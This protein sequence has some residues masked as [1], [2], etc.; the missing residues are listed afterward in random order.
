MAG[1]RD[2][3]LG[4]SAAEIERL[5]F[6][7]RVLE[8]VTERLIRECGVGPGMRAL[9]IGCGVGD[10]S[11]L[12]A[13]AVGESGVVVGIDREAR[14]VEIARERAAKAGYRQIDF[15]V[16]SDENLL[17]YP[18]FDAAVGRYV[19]VHQQDPAATVRRAAAAVRRGGTIA[20][21]EYVVSAIRPAASP[22]TDLFGRVAETVAAACRAALPS[23]DIGCRLVACFEEAGLG[24]PNLI[25]ESIAGGPSSPVIPWIAMTYQGLLPVIKRLGLD[26]PK[27]GDPDTLET[28]VAAAAKAAGSQ[29]VSP[30]QACAWARR[31]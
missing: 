2:Y 27:F 10:V 28:R 5:Q 30:P 18:P 29:I 20:F 9:D 11:M 21:H 25:W 12:L 23:F 31:E 19:L 13:D 26:D 1:D 15:A 16:G 4:H 14:A 24:E 8:G 7:A 22:A 17:E 6:Q 3:V